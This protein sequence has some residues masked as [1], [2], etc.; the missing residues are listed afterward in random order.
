MSTALSEISAA[1]GEVPT[2]RIVNPLEDPQWDENIQRFSTAT[3]FHTT[4]WARVLWET[5]R[6]SPNYFTVTNN[7]RLIAVLPLMEVDSWLTG[8]RGI[9]L[10]FTDEC[11]PLGDAASARALFDAARAYSANRHSKY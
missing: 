2:V 3:I 7:Q 6:F 4:A 10:P 11:P 9:G 1:T 5:Y 8:R